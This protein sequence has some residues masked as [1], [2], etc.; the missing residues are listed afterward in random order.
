MDAYPKKDQVLG[1]EKRCHLEGCGRKDFVTFKSLIA[2]LQ[3][4]HGIAGDELVG[5]WV[6]TECLRE[7]RSVRLGERE[8]EFVSLAQDDEGVVCV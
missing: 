8:A 1:R 7:R 6:H 2:H 3:T 5:H 4:Q